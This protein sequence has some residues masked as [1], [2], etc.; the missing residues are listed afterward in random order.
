MTS[1]FIKVLPLALGAAVSPVIFIL[2]LATLVSRPAP[3][4]RAMFVL[5]GCVGVLAVVMTVIALTD[6]RAGVVSSGTSV[7]SGWIKVALAVLLVLSALRALLRPAVVA[8]EARP[9]ADPVAG[10]TH[11]LRYLLLGVGAMATNFTTF[12]LVV[13]AVHDLNVATIDAGGRALLYAVVALFA[14]LP[15]WLPLAALASLGHRGPAVLD[16]L[17]VWMRAHNRVIV[18][19]VSLAFAAFLAA[20]G[21]RAL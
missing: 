16:R 13:P 1:T 3:V 18:I 5:T 11:S 7:I 10:K 4:R 12:S 6:H 2:Q 9:L 21:L 8:E 19:V 14:L 15:A 20:S 17:S